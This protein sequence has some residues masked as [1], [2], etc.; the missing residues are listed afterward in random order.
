MGCQDKKAA[1]RIDRADDA[2]QSR[3]Q[4][5]AA[6]LVLKTSIPSLRRIVVLLKRL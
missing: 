1:E 6:N 2:R 4:M 3:T 5:N